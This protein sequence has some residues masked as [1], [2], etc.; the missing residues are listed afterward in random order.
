MKPFFNSN[1]TLNLSSLCLLFLHTTL[2]VKVY[3]CH[4][5]LNKALGWSNIYDEFFEFDFWISLFFVLLIM[6]SNKY[7]YKIT[8][9]MLFII[10]VFYLVFND[11]AI[12]IDYEH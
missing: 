5:T 3:A 10:Y 7:F 1:T 8:F 4:L 9:L 11:I 2:I 12:V 6:L